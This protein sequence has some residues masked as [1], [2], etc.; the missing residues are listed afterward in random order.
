MEWFKEDKGKC[1]D[2]GKKPRFLYREERCFKCFHKH[3]DQIAKNESEKIEKESK[4]KCE[5]KCEICGNEHHEKEYVEEFDAYNTLIYIC[6]ECRKPENVLKRNKKKEA[7]DE[8]HKKYGYIHLHECHRCH[9]LT[10]EEEFSDPHW[11]GG[12][13]AY[14]CHLCGYRSNSAWSS[15]QSRQDQNI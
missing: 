3:L 8:I 2:C 1:I 10:M 12:S 5:Y 4:Y 13:Y 15:F 7:I 6:N 14:T 9:E 11:D